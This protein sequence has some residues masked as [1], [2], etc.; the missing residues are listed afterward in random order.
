MASYNRFAKFI[1][2]NNLIIISMSQK[3]IND[4]SPKAWKS[5]IAH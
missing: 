2:S 4:S 5:F 3:L 1:D